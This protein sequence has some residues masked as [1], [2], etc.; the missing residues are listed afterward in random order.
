MHRS[1]VG[2]LGIALVAGNVACVV[3]PRRGV[4]VVGAPVAAVTYVDHEPPPARHE[5]VPAAPGADHVWVGG[6]WRWEGRAYVWV[7]GR[8]VLRP[9]P[10][11]VWVAGHWARHHRGWYWTEGHWR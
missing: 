8:H 5:P 10:R 2:F 4:V 6:F 3:R 7:P 11:A 1:M 9:R